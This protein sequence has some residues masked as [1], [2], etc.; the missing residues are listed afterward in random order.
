MRERDIAELRAELEDI[1]A[2][3]A[4]LRKDLQDREYD[5][6]ELRNEL[7]ILKTELGNDSSSS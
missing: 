7:R 2:T 1:R 3:A 4:R 5:I 6:E